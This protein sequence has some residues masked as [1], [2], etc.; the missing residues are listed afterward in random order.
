MRRL[1]RGADESRGGGSARGSQ[2]SE[3]IID[4]IQPLDTR[5]SSAKWRSSQAVSA[6]LA[7][8]AD[9]LPT[10]MAMPLL[11]ARPVDAAW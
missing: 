5:A 11:A 9:Y 8:G 7:Q 1:T 3:Q 10:V 6:P 4:A 2:R